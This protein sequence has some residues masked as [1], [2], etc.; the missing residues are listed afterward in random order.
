VIGCFLDLRPDGGSVSFSKNGKPFGPAFSLPKH[1]G[2]LYPA[3]C[4]RNA[5]ASVNFGA[6]SFAFPPPAEEGYASVASAS[7]SQVVHASS[8]APD[9]PA[10]G[11]GGRSD[12]SR[13]A[14]GG[15][16]GPVCIIVEPARDLAEQTFK[17]VEE[18]RKYVSTPEVTQACLIGGVDGREATRQLARVP[19][20]ITATPGKLLDL[21]EAGKIALG[22]VRL[23]VL[24]E[25]DRF[26][27]E[28]N[29]R[30][31]SKLYARVRASIDSGAAPGRLQVCFFSATLHSPA[32]GKLADLMCSHPTW[33]DL[34]GKDAVPQ[35]VHHVV[36]PV[37]PSFDRSWAAGSGSG[38]GAVGGGGA[39][40]S[41]QFKTDGVHGS[42]IIHTRPAPPGSTPRC[43]ADD[44]GSAGGGGASAGAAGLMSAEEA[45]EGVKR[46]KQRM[47]L[48]LIDSLRMEQCLIF[49]RTNVDC[50]NLEAYLTQ[51]GGGARFRGGMEKG[52]ENAY[53]SV[54]LAGM[55]TMEERRR[56][57]EAFR[58][59]DVRFLICT[60]VAARGLDIKELPYVINMTLPDESESYI[61]RIGRVGRADRMGLA[62]SLVATAPEKVWYHSCANRG[63]GCSNTRLKE[64]GGCAIWYDERE[65]LRAVQKRL[66]MDPTQGGAGIPAMVMAFNA[67]PPALA[68]KGSVASA[69]AGGAAAPPAAVAPAAVLPYSF[70][71]PPEYAETVYGEESGLVAGTNEHVE[72]I[73]D[74]VTVLA[75]LELKA[76][77][78]FLALQQRFAA[79]ARA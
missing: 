39:D 58:A 44:A 28:E 34:K 52:K 4:V 78:T 51:V 24:D 53:S 26:T 74:K 43:A 13:A 71:L 10:A 72:L 46:L 31:V 79:R 17:A 45:S 2:P 16:L 70:S 47:L 7:P 37:D 23:L 14:A 41:M 32:I 35:T 30:M 19:D 64:K 11:A 75:A 3:V 76:Q 1:A 36:I 57:L 59:G 66:G 50:D 6:S 22:Q 49:C 5:E 73:R 15:P 54:V 12:S 48:S 69:G 67:P 29:F 42:D 65:Q 62:I 61:H 55:R 18:L 40:V 9:A 63:K 20:I 38:R 77:D 25:A 56:N 27:D 68:G 33:V 21:V 8:L 60:D